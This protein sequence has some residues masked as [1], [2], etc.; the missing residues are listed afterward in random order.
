MRSLKESISHAVATLQTHAPFSNGFVM[1]LCS[2]D[3]RK[4]RPLR[5]R[6]S[7]KL[8]SLDSNHATPPKISNGGWQMQQLT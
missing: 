2:S 6:E 3:V 4:L 1:S 5:A 7:I 8:F